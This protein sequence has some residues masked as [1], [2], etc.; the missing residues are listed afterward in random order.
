[1]N[2]CSANNQLCQLT[3]TFTLHPSKSPFFE[4]PLAVMQNSNSF[5]ISA[6]VCR[7]CRGGNKL[8]LRRTDLSSRIMLWIWMCFKYHLSYAQFLSFPFRTQ[9]LK[10]WGVFQISIWGKRNFRSMWRKCFSPWYVMLNYFVLMCKHALC[11]RKM[12]RGNIQENCLANRQVTQAISLVLSWSLLK[13][14]GVAICNS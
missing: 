2:S 11:N 14:K 6:T 8:N 4:N 3:V 10:S 12:E 5:A 13:F 9:Y 1:M 7:V